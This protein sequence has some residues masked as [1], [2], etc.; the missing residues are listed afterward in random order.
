MSN[1]K[2]SDIAKELGIQSKEV[3]A[4]MAGFG[5]SCSKNRNHSQS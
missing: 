4:I 2:V 1:V 5:A 3:I